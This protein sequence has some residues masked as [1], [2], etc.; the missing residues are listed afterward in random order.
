M[1]S[2]NNLNEIL[3]FSF[4]WRSL[5]ILKQSFVVIKTS[6]SKSV[7]PSYHVLKSHNRNLQWETYNG[8]LRKKMVN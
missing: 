7:P 1:G 6:L 4:S 2:L 3:N 5:P 8:V